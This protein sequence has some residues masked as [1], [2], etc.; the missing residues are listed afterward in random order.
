MRSIA[1]ST[2]LDCSPEAAF[3][4]LGSIQAFVHVAKGAVR[5]P[6]AEDVVEPLQVGD[7]VVGWTFLF[8]YLPI[9]RHT[10]RIVELDHHAR[11]LVSN[12]HGGLVKRWDHTITV[13]PLPDGG[14][15]YEDQIDI[16]AGLFTPVVAAFAHVFYR[17]RQRRWRRLA[18]RE[19]E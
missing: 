19:L 13:E 6:A 3:E 8:R 5:F 9:A 2:H 15:R 11:R 10:L 4:A 14:S 16:D 18:E 1:V 17:H 7:E 12:E